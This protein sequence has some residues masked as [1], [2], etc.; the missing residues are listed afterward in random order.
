[1]EEFNVLKDIKSKRFDLSTDKNKLKDYIGKVRVY[2]FINKFNDCK[3]VGS[4]IDLYKRLT[5]GY[6]T[7]VLGKRKFDL[8]IL[9]EELNY[10]Y[11]DNI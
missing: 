9:S 3:Y 7:P 11:L 1:M 5:S 2:V 8:V 4:S 10:F 6:F